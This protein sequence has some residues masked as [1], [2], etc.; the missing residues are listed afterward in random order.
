MVAQKEGCCHIQ[1]VL[2]ESEMQRGAKGSLRKP[3]PCY[4]FLQFGENNTQQS[5][6]FILLLRAIVG[7]I[8]V[9]EFYMFSVILL[10]L[11][12]KSRREH[13]RTTPYHCEYFSKPLTSYVLLEETSSSYE[14][15]S[16]TGMQKIVVSEI[17]NWAI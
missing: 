16:T 11:V 2:I 13:A 10:W 7:A 9:G 14:C 5:C 15:V 4:S 3:L 17:S 12:L 8:S 6:P 1:Q